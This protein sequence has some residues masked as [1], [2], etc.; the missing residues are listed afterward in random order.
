MPCCT[1]GETFPDL[2]L[3]VPGGQ[4]VLLPGAFAGRFGVVLFYRGSWCPYCNAQLHAFQRASGTLASLSVQVAALS[5][6][7][8]A[9]TADLI[10]KHH[11]TYPVGFGPTPARSRTWPA[12]SSTRTRCTCS[13]P[14]SSSTRQATSWSASTP[15][16]PSA[17]SSPRTSPASSATCATTPRHR[18]RRQESHTE[19]QCLA[20]A[21]GCKRNVPVI[22]LASPGDRCYETLPGRQDPGA[23][24][25][26]GRPSADSKG[27]EEADSQAACPPGIPGSRPGHLSRRRLTV[28]PFHR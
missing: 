20:A 10:A 25:P 9:S 23:A 26:L 4:T 7:D 13:P 28:S 17:G 11:L 15:A 12:P 21:A 22:A 27:G 19:R 8:E 3:T 2:T 1:P 14:A 16:E 24:P 6:D 5:V 18:P